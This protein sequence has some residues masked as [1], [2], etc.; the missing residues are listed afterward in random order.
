MSIRP[1]KTLGFTQEKFCWRTRA[2]LFRAARGQL[3]R[4]GPLFVPF[5]YQLGQSSLSPRCWTNDWTP[6][7]PFAWQDGDLELCEEPI[8][9][10]GLFIKRVVDLLLS[11]IGLVALW[12]LMLAIALAV[13]LE[14]PGPAVYRSLR[15]GKRGHTFPCY[16]FRTM[17]TGADELKDNLR[18]L[19]QRRGPFFKIADDPRVTHLGRF[20][21]KYSLDELP[22]LWNVLK[23]DMSLVGPRPHPLED[24]EQYSF[25]HYRRLEVKPGITGLWQ[26][27]A[28]RNPS[29]EI[30]MVLDLRYI[31]QWNFLLDCRILVKTISAV[32]AGE[33]Q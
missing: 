13:K 22:Q 33:G 2:R 17:I 3:N 14:S 4:S 21:R 7:G 12:P 8:P 6:L 9:S 26:V 18:S 1:H 25:E 32:L 19:N 23:G 15:A 28:R 31:R 24:C 30:C 10:F 20:L 29:F 27:L 5:S 11:F 16:K